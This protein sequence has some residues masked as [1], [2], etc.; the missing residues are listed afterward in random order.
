MDVAIISNTVIEDINVL[1]IIEHIMEFCKTAIRECVDGKKGG[2]AKDITEIINCFLESA[3]DP[4]YTESLLGRPLRLRQSVYSKETAKEAF[5]DL[6]RALASFSGLLSTDPQEHCRLVFRASVLRMEDVFISILEE[7]LDTDKAK[8]LIAYLERLGRYAVAVR[9]LHMM[10]GHRKASK[11]FSMYS[12]AISFT[13]GRVDELTLPSLQQLQH[14]LMGPTHSSYVDYPAKIRRAYSQLN[15][16]CT[17]KE[18]AEM[19]LLRFYLENPQITPVINCFGISKYCCYFC[20]SLLKEL[21]DP[22]KP[23]KPVTFTIR[24][25]HGKVYG[26]WLPPKPSNASASIQIRVASCLKAIS[27]DVQV[28]FKKRIEEL[29][30]DSTGSDSSTWSPQVEGFV[31]GGIAGDRAGFFN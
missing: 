19:Q 15:E 9:T 8:V 4:G 1:N 20:T 18:H 17:V 28:R 25:S 5:G 12:V 24:S 26:H 31:G 22:N 27:Q 10:R 11:T 14:L 23:G 7:A 13:Q 16:R 30:R 3:V 2:K 21:Q 6:V 29:T